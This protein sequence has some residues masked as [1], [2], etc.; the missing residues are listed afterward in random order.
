MIQ[1]SVHIAVKP[2]LSN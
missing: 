2:G 1:F